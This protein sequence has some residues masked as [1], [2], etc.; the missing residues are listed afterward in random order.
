VVVFVVT[1]L[2]TSARQLLIIGLRPSSAGSNPRKRMSLD[3]ES[4]P[5]SP[6][7]HVTFSLVIRHYF[8]R[9]EDGHAG[10]I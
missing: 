5:Q 7:C 10:S 2:W 9:S 6:S 3:I 1:A 8:E 4:G